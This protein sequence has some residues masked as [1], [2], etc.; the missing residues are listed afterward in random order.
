MPV[1]F[2]D[3]FSSKGKKGGQ[4]MGSEGSS[5]SSLD[6]K[7]KFS[8]HLPPQIGA[9]AASGCNQPG[10]GDTMDQNKKIPWSTIPFLNVMK[11]IQLPKEDGKGEIA[12]KVQKSVGSGALQWTTTTKVKQKKK[13][14][15]MFSPSSF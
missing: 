5:S 4:S 2:D 1:S 8:I 10:K 11:T 3:I 7:E 15:N 12:N 13:E 9:T 14:L 6:I